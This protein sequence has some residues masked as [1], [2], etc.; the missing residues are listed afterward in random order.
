[1]APFFMLVC[2]VF[3]FSDLPGDEFPGDFVVKAARMSVCESSCSAR[4]QSSTQE[5]S[6]HLNAWQRSRR[7]PSVYSAFPREF[8]A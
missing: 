3:S 2:L 1:V 6:V 8:S 7:S 5:T 4:P